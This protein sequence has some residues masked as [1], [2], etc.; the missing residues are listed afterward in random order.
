MKLDTMIQ[1]INDLRTNA[2]T[3]DVDPA[4]VLLQ[5]YQTPYDIITLGDSIRITN[6]PLSTVYTW[7]DGTTYTA[8]DNNGN[9]Y[10]AP[11]CGWTWGSGGLYKVYPTA[12]SFDGVDDYVDCGNGVSLQLT[13]GTME[14]WIKTTDAGS[15]YRGVIV[16]QLAYSL[17][18]V[19]N[20]LTLF[21]W[22]AGVA[23]STA[24]NLADGIWHHVAVSFQ[25]GVTNGTIIYVDGLPVLTTTMTVSSQSKSF[26]IANGSMDS[27]GQYFTGIIDESRVWN[28]IRSQ[29][30]IQANMNNQLVGNEAGL[31]G[32][33]KFNEANGTIAHDS[34]ANANHGTLVNGTAWTTGIL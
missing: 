30:Q 28:V 32:Y 21:D 10:D 17:F 24:V 23:Q 18:L 14:A 5:T 4:N 12:L 27:F 20:I 15:S 31:V 33:W 19:D 6:R 1:L 11:S 8:Y 25:S 9:P 22:T 3:D 2:I 7:S 26:G 34:T 16:K 13:V 29:A